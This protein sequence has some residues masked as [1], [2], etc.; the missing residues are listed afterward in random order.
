MVTVPREARVKRSLPPPLQDLFIGTGN[1]IGMNLG[2]VQRTATA[3]VGAGVFALGAWS[4]STSSAPSVRI[5]IE[6][7][8]RI[9]ES[10]GLPDHPTGDFPNPGNP[11]RIAARSH[12]FRIPVDPTPAQGDARGVLFGVAVNGIPFDPGTAEL[13]NGDFRWHY[14]ALSGMLARGNRLGVDRNRAHVQPDGTYHYHGIPTG[15]VEKL[16]ADTRMVQVGWAADGY[17]IYSNLGPTDPSNPRSP[18]KRLRSGWRLRSGERQGTDGPGGTFD[19]SF[20]QDYEFVAGLGDLDAFNGRS[21]PTPEFPKGTYYYVLTDTFPF[22]PRQLKG[23][24]DATFR[25]GPP[26]SGGPGVG[27][28]APPARG[29]MA[30]NAKSVYILRG[31]ELIEFDPETRAVRNR[32]RLPSPDRP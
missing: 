25:K 9:L 12:R 18:L 30:A 2:I 8:H 5:R 15:L 21:G 10:N 26:P 24:P 29:A 20:Q 13:W 7:S 1:N 17:P 31:D 3:L 14:E 27:G 28:G 19:G 32:T 6:G 4:Q 23:V 22:V 16:G 11:N